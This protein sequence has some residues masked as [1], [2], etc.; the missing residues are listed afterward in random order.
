MPVVA[1][2]GGVAAG[3]STVTAVLAEL[4]AHVI[5]AD[6]LARQAVAPGSSALA[7]VIA[8]FGDTVEADDGSLDRQ[9]LGAIVF[10]NS[11]ARE[12]LNNIV[13]P[14]VRRLYDEALATA[15]RDSAR[16][17]VY[18]VP[19]LTEARFVREFDVVVVVH[20][21]AP[22]RQERLRKERGFTEE[23]AVARIQSQASDDERLAVADIILDSSVS[24][25][26][27]TEKA[28][29]LFEVLA[30]CWPDRLDEAPAVYQART[31]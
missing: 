16:V 15:Q 18:D 21:P 27:T 10:S 23:Q 5:D 1:V 8:H 11:E 24:R 22:L 13:H 3:K 6:V 9:A 14:E 29:I 19:L 26:D 31:S 28:R 20:S 4:G 30:S 17:V 25:F 7:Q 12:A 2:T